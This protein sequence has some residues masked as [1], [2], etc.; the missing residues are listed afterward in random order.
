MQFFLDC[1]P[2]GRGDVSSLSEFLTT[3]NESSPRAWGCFLYLTHPEDFECVFPTGVGMF[4]NPDDMEVIKARLPH[5]RGDVSVYPV[6]ITLEASSSP[7]AWGCFRLK[8][9]LLVNPDV[10]PTG[11]GMFPELM[12]SSSRISCLPHGRGDVSVF[13]SISNCISRSSPRA[14]GCFQVSSLGGKVKRVFPTGV[15]MFLC[16]CGSKMM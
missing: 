4:L 13:D 9:R 11:V 10:F 16:W 3:L 5:G 8:R 12:L 6:T 14:W 1:L 2:H 15:G 7:R